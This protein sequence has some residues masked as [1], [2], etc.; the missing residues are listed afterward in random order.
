MLFYFLDIEL[1]WMVKK[2]GKQHVRTF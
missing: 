1:N 2:S